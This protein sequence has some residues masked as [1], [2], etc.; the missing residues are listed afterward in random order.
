MSKRQVEVDFMTLPELRKHF[1]KGRFAT[2][3]FTKKTNGEIRV[4]NGKTYVKRGIVGTGGSSSADMLNV[5]DV[6]LKDEN[7]VRTGDYRKVTVANVLEVSAN[8]KIYIVKHPST[9][10][11]FIT[12]V[13]V[14]D[15]GVV[16]VEMF[17]KVRIYDYFGID[18]M[19]AYK[20]QRA[21]NKGA[22][23][24]KLIKGKYVFSQVK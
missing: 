4:L 1:G 17:G 15:N 9:L 3:K 8:K 20:F 23:F 7:G 24:N 2:V 19:T 21:G 11:N 18:A 10:V 6:N 22:F 13:I 5:F 16:R 14:A 12:N